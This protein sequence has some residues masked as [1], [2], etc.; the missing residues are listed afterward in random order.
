GADQAYIGGRRLRA[1]GLPAAGLRAQPDLQGLHM[2]LRPGG[3]TQSAAEGLSMT[4]LAA[5]SMETP[6]F[7]DADDA[8]I[9]ALIYAGFSALLAS[10]FELNEPRSVTVAIEAAASG[11]SLRASDI[12][13]LKPADVPGSV[14]SLYSDLFV[15]DNDG[16]FVLLRVVLVRGRGVVAKKDVTRY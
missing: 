10:P 15:G 14:H 12:S 4:A 16:P 11:T 5:K 8:R 9:R 7:R 2:R 1:P 3:K 6:R 13:E